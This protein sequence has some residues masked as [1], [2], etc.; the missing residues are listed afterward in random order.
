MA[1]QLLIITVLCNDQPGIV[2]QL[3]D[4]ISNHDGNWLESHMNRLAGKFA[5][6]ITVDIA[7]QDRETL[8]A[9]LKGL[10][11][12]GIQVLVDTAS[13]PSTQTG[14]TITFDVV[15]PDRKGIISEIAQA[16]SEKG[17]NIEDM[18]TACSSMPW[19]GE[20]L[21]EAQGILLAPAEINTEELLDQLDIIEDKLGLD[22]TLSETL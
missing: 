18:Q 4:M 19:S 13:T 21:F 12:E 16:F 20:P 22:I 15:G 10:S 1:N 6:T 2:R 11:S 5:G 17:I 14:K 9:A 7:N 8:S 3:A